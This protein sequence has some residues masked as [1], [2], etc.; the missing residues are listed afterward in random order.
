MCLNLWHAT[1]PLAIAI[2]CGPRFLGPEISYNYRPLNSV[3]M[4]IFMQF[5]VDI[6]S[7]GRRRSSYNIEFAKG[8]KASGSASK[9]DLLKSALEIN[10]RASNSSV[11]SKYDKMS[12]Q[13][14]NRKRADSAPKLNP[15]STK[16]ISHPA[17]ISV[18][19]EVS[20]RRGEI[21]NEANIQFCNFSR[22]TRTPSPKR[23]RLPR[24]SPRL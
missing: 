15:N 22:T 12:N 8:H 2:H 4:A 5:Q 9:V 23:L 13:S 16:N 14:L 3:L 17:L 10:H 21:T 11:L 18:V 19:D 24:Q 7:L 6:D 20:Y 1:L